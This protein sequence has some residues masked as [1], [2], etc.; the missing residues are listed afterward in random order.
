MEDGGEEEEEEE[1]ESDFDASSEIED[2]RLTKA[3]SSFVTASLMTDIVSTSRAVVSRYR[4]NL[5]RSMGKLT[6]RMWTG[7]F[8]LPSADDPAS[9]C[10]YK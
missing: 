5:P 2:L 9:A 7:Q 8:L 6:V 3:K 10:C 4:V 1:E